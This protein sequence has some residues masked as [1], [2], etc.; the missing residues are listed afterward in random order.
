MVQKATK[1]QEDVR[2]VNVEQGCSHTQFPIVGN[3]NKLV[4]LSSQ[5]RALSYRTSSSWIHYIFIALLRTKL[6]L[7]YRYTWDFQ[8]R[9]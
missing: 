7:L 3:N 2:S 6:M 5:I 1:G 9:P 4:L 8:K